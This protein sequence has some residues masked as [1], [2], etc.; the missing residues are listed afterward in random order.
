MWLAHYVARLDVF[1][2]ALNDSLI[3]RGKKTFKGSRSL[4]NFISYDY[5]TFNQTKGFEK[6][7]HKKWKN[8][9]YIVLS[10]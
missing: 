6:I 5:I 7:L 4:Q 9:N 2:G 10:K 8:K 3:Y 1:F